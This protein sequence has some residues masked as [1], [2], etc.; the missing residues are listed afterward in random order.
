MAVPRSN[1]EW[2]Y[3]GEHDPL[4]GVLTVPGRS[5]QG[6]RPW[7]LAEV[8]EQGER[9]FSE[10]LPH[11]VS[12]GIGREHCVEIGCGTGQLTARLVASFA[13][14][15]GI[16]VSSH[17]L[18]SA[19]QLLGADIERVKLV[20]VEAPHIPLA[21]ASCD[22]VFSCEVFQ[23]FDSEDTAVEYLKEAFRVLSPGGTICVHL[24]IAGL[25]PRSGWWIRARNFLLR[26]ARNVGRK[27]MMIYRW[28]SAPRVITLLDHL[29]FCRVQG[30][31]HFSHAHGGAE[32]YFFATKPF[33][34]PAASPSISVQA[35]GQPL[36]NH[37]HESRPIR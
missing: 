29:G 32:A 21:D 20:Q 11:W 28:Y 16:D 37:Q 15:T 14:V 12:Y 5:R 2:K 34:A 10:I 9:Y 22:G 7:S 27:R 30:L 31:L 3:W 23:H 35:S 8:K 26:I 6:S 19:R 13:T 17:Q 1:R 18:E 36:L 4:F 24:P 33:S 25:Q